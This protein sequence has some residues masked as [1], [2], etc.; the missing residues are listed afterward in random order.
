MTTTLNH[1][2]AHFVEVGYLLRVERFKIAARRFRVFFGRVLAG[3]RRAAAR[4]G[5]IGPDN[6]PAHEQ[7]HAGQGI[8]S[9]HH[10]RKY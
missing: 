7:R 4:Q 5:Y 10:I 2:L 6:G 1:C 9:V 3:R 8:S